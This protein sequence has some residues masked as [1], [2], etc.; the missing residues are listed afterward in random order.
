MKEIDGKIFPRTMTDV[1]VL[2]QDSQILLDP[3]SGCPNAT[4]EGA[5]PCM[6]N[7]AGISEVGIGVVCEPNKLQ[8]TGVR[9]EGSIPMQSGDLPEGEI[10][11]LVPTELKIAAD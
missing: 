4:P 10:I 8:I 9:I 7:T 3:C 2:M 1:R 6:L 11:S 5:M